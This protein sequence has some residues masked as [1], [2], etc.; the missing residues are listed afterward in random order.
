M[1]PTIALLPSALLGPAVWQPVR[2][3][4]HDIGQ[5]AIVVGNQEASG[6]SVDD[7]LQW[8][9]NSLPTG[10]DYVL[11]PHSNAGLYVPASTAQ[12]S[13][14]G[15]VVVDAIRVGQFPDLVGRE[16]R[17]PARSMA[18]GWWWAAQDVVWWHRPLTVRNHDVSSYPR[19]AVCRGSD[20][21]VS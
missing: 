18:T 19:A 17:V 15:L 12:R 7:V 4:L 13:V 1:N 20:T 8:Y 16:L 11:V 9:L 5:D 14:T 10:R 2:S 6:T 21:G 3:H